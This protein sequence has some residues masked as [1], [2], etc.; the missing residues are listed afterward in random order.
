MA[1]R[2][3]C[4][5]CG[6]DVPVQLVEVVWAEDAM[7]LCAVC[8]GAGLAQAQHDLPDSHAG[9]PRALARIANAMMDAHGPNF[10]DAAELRL[11]GENAPEGTYEA[12]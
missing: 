12:V 7:A 11:R 8:D 9:M 3:M 6:C 10:R 5:C 1:G 2:T 4:E